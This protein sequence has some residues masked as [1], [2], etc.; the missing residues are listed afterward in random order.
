M[1]VHADPHVTMHQDAVFELRI[2]PWGVTAPV[3][4]IDVVHT[5]TSAGLTYGTLPG[6]PLQ[7]EER[8]TIRLGSDGVTRADILGFSRPATPLS[9]LA[10]P[11]VRHYRQKITDRFLAALK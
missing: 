8:V 4:V 2:G 3:R 5:A 9:R 1:L 7:G 10:T 6:H 11:V